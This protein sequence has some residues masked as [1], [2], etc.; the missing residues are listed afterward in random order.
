MVYRSKPSAWEPA[1]VS[2][3]LSKD[4]CVVPSPGPLD[5]QNF[6]FTR[7]RTIDRLDWMDFGEGPTV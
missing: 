2:V 3:I 7:I 5:S 1:T 4:P 6:G